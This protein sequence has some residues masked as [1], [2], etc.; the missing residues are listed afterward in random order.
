[1]VARVEQCVLYHF[2]TDFVAFV[3]FVLVIISPDKMQLCK[4]KPEIVQERKNFR[5]KFRD[6]FH[7][8]FCAYT[9]WIEA[10]HPCWEKVGGGSLHLQIP[11]A[12]KVG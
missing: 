12:W 1:M 11:S 3:Q 4:I 8:D 7:P 2:K 6:F 5:N 10:A 9:E